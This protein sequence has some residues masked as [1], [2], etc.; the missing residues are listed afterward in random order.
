MQKMRAQ[1]GQKTLEN[2]SSTR[3]CEQLHQANVNA[4]FFV[5]HCMRV[6]MTKM[7]QKVEEENKC[8]RASVLAKA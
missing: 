7:Q 3:L 2:E 4:L 1:I 5:Q 6:E 8:M